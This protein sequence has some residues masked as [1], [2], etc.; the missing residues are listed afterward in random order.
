MILNDSYSYIDENKQKAINELVKNLKKDGKRVDLLPAITKRNADNM[1][2][3]NQTPET[4]NVLAIYVLSKVLED[5]NNIGIDMIV[6][7]TNYKSSLIYDT[8][9]KHY[10][11]THENIRRQIC[12]F[13]GIVNKKVSNQI[14]LTDLFLN[15]SKRRLRQMQ[16][17]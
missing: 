5:M 16:E 14:L 10:T 9:N 6:R 17:N 4:P 15:L 2:M 8:I 1:S 13:S 3:K 7:D 12:Q 11:L